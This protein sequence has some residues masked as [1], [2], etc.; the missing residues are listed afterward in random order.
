MERDREIEALDESIKRVE[1][2]LK[3]DSIVGERRKALVRSLD[4]LREIRALLARK[5][6]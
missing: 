3:N 6:H 5:L 2:Q 4:G 1:E